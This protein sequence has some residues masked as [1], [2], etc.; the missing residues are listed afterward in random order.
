MG[1]DLNYY[2][3]WYT[4][5]YGDF[6]P[7]RVE[8]VLKRAHCK[9]TYYLQMII[10]AG[11][12]FP[13][14]EEALWAS[15]QI[16]AFLSNIQRQSS[17]KI[18]HLQAPSVSQEKESQEPSNQQKNHSVNTCEHKQQTVPYRKSYETREHCLE[19]LLIKIF[20]S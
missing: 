19:M 6:Y 17:A 11:N 1:K 9:G 13:T 12:I 14:R 8:D 16:S 3:D 10:D 18:Q 2:K 15:K 5:R 7:E 20:H 4:L